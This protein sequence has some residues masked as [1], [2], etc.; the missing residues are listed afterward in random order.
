M[1]FGRCPAAFCIIVLIHVDSWITTRLLLNIN[2]S[3]GIPL[4][5][6]I[7][8]QVAWM[9]STGQLRAGDTLPSVRDVARHH[10]IN[11]MTVSKAYSLMEAEGLVE[12]QRGKP[13]RI[14][15]KSVR[16]ESLA[17]RLAWIEP[18]I[19]QLA[20]KA[21]QLDIPAN[22][23]LDAIGHCLEGNEHE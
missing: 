18:E 2:T 23:L 22:A 21:R 7:M 5:R 11:P 19:R 3:S 10:D 6:Q 1:T 13:M 17:Q 4:Y 9:V 8:D 15:S 16:P 14:R 12:R 20:T